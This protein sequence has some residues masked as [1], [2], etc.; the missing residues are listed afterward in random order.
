MQKGDGGIYQVELAFKMLAAFQRLDEDEAL[1]FGL[2]RGLAAET[3]VAM[4]RFSTAWGLL[5]EVDDMDE[6]DLECYYREYFATGS[7]DLSYD[8]TF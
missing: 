1:L 4:S 2:G 5:F 3:L 7:G 6:A 8:M